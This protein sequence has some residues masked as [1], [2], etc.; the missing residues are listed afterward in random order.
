MPNTPDSVCWQAVGLLRAGHTVHATQVKN[1][2]PINRRAFE[3]WQRTGEVKH[4]A[5]VGRPSLSTERNDRQIQRLAL[6]NRFTSAT[7]LRH[8]WTAMTRH[9]GPLSAKIVLRRLR[10]FGVPAKFIKKY[11]QIHF[12]PS[13]KELWRE[14]GFSWT[15][16]QHLT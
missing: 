8:L 16:M 11:W 12:Y 9:G 5:G 2:L 4:A 13:R 10:S 6:A 7:T 3:K 14:D 1:I 15:T